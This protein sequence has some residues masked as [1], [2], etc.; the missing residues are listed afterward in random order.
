MTDCQT[1]ETGRM[2]C[3]AVRIGG[4]SQ[5]ILQPT[6]LTWV[7]GTAVVM[8]VVL[9]SHTEALAKGRGRGQA[10][11]EKTLSVGGLDRSYYL[12]VPSTVRA[13]QAPL[14]V[15]FH[16]GGQD[17]KRFAMGV[18]L[19]EMADRYGFVMAV[20]EGIQKSWNT[21]SPHPQGYAEENGIN[22]LAFVSAVLDD[23]LALGVANPTK[24]L[25]W[26]F[27]GAV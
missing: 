14:V 5:T 21:G 10:M 20:P 24:S 12:Y 23:V 8:A 15:A 11:Q 25:R 4:Y 6:L 7:V 9:I 2:K 22:D 13:G 17:V 19:Q 16:G 18:G 27:R 26:E 3:W 1:S